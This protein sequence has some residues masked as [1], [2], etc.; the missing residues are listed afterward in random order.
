MQKVKALFFLVRFPNLIIIALTQFLIAYY[1]IH[2]EFDIKLYALI[3][4]TVL[5]AASGNIINDYFD[6]RFD[7]INK[8]N[9]IW[10]GKVFKRRT[11][12]ILHWVI[13]ILAVLIGAVSSIYVGIVDVFCVSL[14]WFYSQKLKCVPL[15]GNL[16]VSFLTAFVVFIMVLKYG[17]FE[18]DIYLLI[19][20]SFLLNFIR[21]I[22]K[23]IEDIRGDYTFDCKTIATVNGIAYSKKILVSLQ[24]VLVSSFITLMFFL[25]Y[26]F[27][28]Y[29]VFTLLPL[30]LILFYKTWK[31]HKKKHFKTLSRIEKLLILIGVCSLVIFSL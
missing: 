15:L 3:L 5:V 22:T 25:E 26:K 12:L 31:A 13:S 29:I 2:A 20:F 17:Y 21:E 18:S 27:Q 28:L 4:S 8:P 11:I 30:S 19:Y 16:I 1:V 10:V 14:L 24:F 9:E 7:H 23:D 6:V